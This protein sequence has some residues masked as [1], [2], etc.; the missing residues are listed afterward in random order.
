M[1]ATKKGFSEDEA[2]DTAGHA[3]EDGDRTDAS[4]MA[5]PEP[6]PAASPKPPL[7]P[8]VKTAPTAAAASSPAS[9]KPPVVPSA[10]TELPAR[11][12]SSSASSSVAPPATSTTAAGVKPVNSASLPLF[13][14]PGA[15]AE[16]ALD[17]GD[18]LDDAPLAPPEPDGVAARALMVAALL[19]RSRF[20]TAP[21]PKA[22]AALASWVEAHGL[23]GNLGAEGAE[24]FDAP[25][26]QWTKEDL[27]AVGWSAEE[28]PVLLWALG[29][30]DFPAFEARA[31]VGALLARLPMG[32][33]LEPFFAGAT[34]RPVAELEAHRATWETMLEVVRSEAYARSLSEDPS[35]LEDD[36]DL[37][38]VLEAAEQEGFDRAAAARQ[39]PV[40]EA[41]G[42]LR[43]W[44]K[45]LLAELRE[46]GEVPL[47]GAAL[48]AMKDERLATVLGLSHARVEALT[49][50]LEGDEYVEDDEG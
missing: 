32:E 4:G 35:S 41:Q 3:L 8:S 17:D 6:A 36:E 29:L 19:Q 28:L 24:L 45:T 5:L 30:T 46:R 15:P 48:T 14:M 1:A 7:A 42:A 38:V 34:V 11:A 13:K 16:D 33:D 9:S 18:D 23:F 27:E 10:K 50:L 44:V 43:F 25:S 2:T 40:V 47:D 12:A 21:D 26:G 39:G 22:Q 37:Q 20:E 49:W 31:D